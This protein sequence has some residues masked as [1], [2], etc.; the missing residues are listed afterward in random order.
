MALLVSPEVCVVSYGRGREGVEVGH[1]EHRR[2][3]PDVIAFAVVTVSDTRDEVEDTSGRLIGELVLGAGHKVVGRYRVRDEREEIES[4]TR[5]LIDREE[6]DWIVLTGGSGI[7]KRDVSV[8][9]LSPLIEKRIEGFGELFRYLSYID[10]GSSAV[11]SRARAGTARGK[12]IVLLPGSEE[13][14]RLAMERLVI[15]EAGHMVREVRR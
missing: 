8:E 14:V 12:I 10:I 11:L 15:P 4:L 9:A 5:E 1:E 13:A 3:A 6:I 2:D 7:S